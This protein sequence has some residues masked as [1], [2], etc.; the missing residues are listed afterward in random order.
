M[1]AADE[2]STAA[3]AAVIDVHKR[4]GNCDANRGA[5]LVLQA[6]ELHALVGENGAG[7]ST[8]MRIF[9]GMT[10]PDRGEIHIGGKTVGK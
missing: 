5:S 10:P 1:S 7:K 8:L 4:F 9:A 3:A 6:G 2:R